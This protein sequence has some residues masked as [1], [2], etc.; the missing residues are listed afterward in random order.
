M[1]ITFYYSAYNQ[2]VRSL[3]K[4]IISSQN[5]RVQIMD[6]LYS[7]L[8]TISSKVLTNQAI[9]ETGLN[10][11]IEDPGELADL[12]NFQAFTDIQVPGFADN[13][14]R[15]YF[16]IFFDKELVFNPRF[17]SSIETFAKHLYE[18]IP[19]SPEV[20]WLS[21]IKK[22]Q[23]SGVFLSD[24]RIQEKFLNQSLQFIPYVRT[25]SHRSEIVGAIIILVSPE[26]LLQALHIQDPFREKVIHVLDNRTGDSIFSDQK[27][28]EP[29]DLEIKNILQNHS[30]LDPGVIHQIADFYGVQHDSAGGRWRI[31]TLIHKNVI[32]EQVA[33]IVENTTLIILILIIVSSLLL[34]YAVYLSQ[35]PLLKIVNNLISLD[36]YDIDK[37]KSKQLSGLLADLTGKSA[38]IREKMTNLRPFLTNVFLTNLLNG[39][40]RSADLENMEIIREMKLLGQTYRAIVMRIGSRIPYIRQSDRD[41][42]RL[43]AKIAILDFLAYSKDNRFHPV[44]LEGQMIG[45]IEKDPDENA[46]TTLTSLIHEITSLVDEHIEVGV[47]QVKVS[48]PEISQSYYEASIAL[49]SLDENTQVNLAYYQHELAEN[50]PLTYYPL[51]ME[52]R[53]KYMVENHM[54]DETL[55]LLDELF[56]LNSENRHSN[57][58]TIRLLFS[59]LKG[60]L[61]R[62]MQD[63]SVEDEKLIEDIQHIMI[64]DKE[65]PAEMLN[66]FK[67]AFLTVITSINTIRTSKKDTLKNQIEEYL[68]KNYSDI[69]LSITMIASGFNYSPQYFSVVFK[70]IF[71]TNFRVYLEELR[72]TILVAKLKEYPQKDLKELLFEVGYSSQNTFSKAFKR[73]FGISAT[74]FRNN[75]R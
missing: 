3:E 35:L 49:N 53:V 28:Q 38:I 61:I 45:I 6:N 14:I 9:L 50:N 24:L 52:E 30:S 7:N 40:I 18:F 67:M 46:P 65:D 8:T 33:F 5:I 48:L 62:I 23:Y 44:N 60:T 37:D 39:E 17:T 72:L 19:S 25:I 12:L 29:H 2:A 42:E 13:V 41:H 57:Q 15:D 51:K 69:N 55:S 66:Q 59:L 56:R 74:E 36:D 11:S 34:M 26:N 63:N 71:A 32:R 70:D 47:G 68:Q 20:D 75:L 73:H 22:E 21:L 54:E 16:V 10:K 4:E 31:V 64:L 58:F 43:L 27:N 1:G